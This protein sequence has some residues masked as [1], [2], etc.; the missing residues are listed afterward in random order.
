V[1]TL[2]PAQ[3]RARSP[4]AHP[5]AI[6]ETGAPE[7][8]VVVVDPVVVDP[9]VVDPV[10]VVVDTSVV[11]DEGGVVRAVVVRSVVGRRAAA[12]GW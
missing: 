4:P 11:D 12:S 3:E 9:V 8:T 7:A 10:V 2:T 6:V 5:L 1:L